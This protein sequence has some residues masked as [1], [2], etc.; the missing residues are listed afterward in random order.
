MLQREGG[1]PHGAVVEVRFVTKA[2]GG[3]S[4][5]ELLTALEEADDFVVFGVSGHAVPSAGREGGCSFFDDGM[6]ALGE[7][8]IGRG[9]F[10]NLGEDVHFAIG[11]FGFELA[12]ALPHRGAFFVRKSFGRLGGGWCLGFGFHRAITVSLS[13]STFLRGRVIG[14]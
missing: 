9:H 13:L 12:G 14:S 4:G 8:A 7:G 5:F 6:E 11:V 3:V 1:G 10:G 2:E